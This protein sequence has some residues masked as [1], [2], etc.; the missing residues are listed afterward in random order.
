M[1]RSVPNDAKSGLARI[2]TDTLAACRLITLALALGA[3]AK[4]RQLLGLAFFSGLVV[5]QA[6]TLHITAVIYL[7]LDRFSGRGPALTAEGSTV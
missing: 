3:G 4:L 2:G 5:S 7:D 1:L 6:V